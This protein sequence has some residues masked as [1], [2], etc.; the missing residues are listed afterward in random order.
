MRGR[1]NPADGDLYVCGLSAWGSTQTLQLGGLY[2][3]KFRDD[4]KTLIPTGL[5]AT[6]NGMRI[7]FTHAPDQRTALDISNYKIE[8]WDLLRSR[9]Y[10][11]DHYNTK[12]LKA[13]KAELSS[14]G[15]TLFLT[16]PGI[17]P[18]HVMEINYRLKDAGGKEVNGL[19]QNT[20]HYLSDK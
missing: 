18:T 20:I 7:Q 2:R 19:V 9:K 4:G 16:I 8:T 13:T 6:K 15:K 11:S 1:F 10:G 3:V 14:D 17:K 12:S 5:H